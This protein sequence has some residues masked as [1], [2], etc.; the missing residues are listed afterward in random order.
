MKLMKKIKLTLGDFQKNELKKH[1]LK[2]IN[3]GDDTKE[4]TTA[5]QASDPPITIKPPGQG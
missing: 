5:R 4:I 3:G 2:M 1:H